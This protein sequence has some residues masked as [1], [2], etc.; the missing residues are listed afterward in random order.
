MQRLRVIRSLLSLLLLVGPGL[1]APAL[2]AEPTIHVQ[3]SAHGLLIEPLVPAAGWQLTVSG[4]SG[5]VTRTFA[6][7][8]TISFR[9]DGL[10]D[11]ADGTWT[12]ELVRVPALDA[13]TRALLDDA[14]GTPEERAV[15]E[16][17]EAAGR[18]PRGALTRSGAFQVSDG[19]VI[20]AETPDPQRAPAT[21]G[22]ATKPELIDDDLL[23][24]EFL[25][26]GDGCQ[27][28]TTTPANDILHLRDA[29]M[30][31]FFEDTTSFQGLPM[32]D[33]RIDINNTAGPGVTAPN[34][35]RFAIEDSDDGTT[36]FTISDDVPDHS[37]FLASSGQVGLGTSTPAA[38]LHV[39]DGSTPTLRLEQD[40]TELFDLYAWDI[41]ADDSAL[42]IRDA[43]LL[44]EPLTVEAG[45]PSHALVVKANG[46][47][48]LGT[49]APGDDFHLL[50]TQNA[51]TFATIQNEDTG[52][53]AAAVLKVDA[54]G[55]GTNL[56]AHGSGR[57]VSR[58]GETLGGWNELLSFTGN[59]LILGTSNY[60]SR[61]V[62]GTEGL[63][64]LE[65]T[66][67]QQVLFNGTLVHAD[68]VFEPDYELPSISEQTEYM[69][70]ERHLPAIGP[71]RVAEDG[72]EVMELGSDRRAIVEELEKA[73]IYIGQL[74]DRLRRIEMELEAEDPSCGLE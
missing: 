43:A 12:W 73:H 39:R 1:G 8:E 45:A 6:T 58:F 32:G 16:S 55:S 20:T 31:V 28:P 40:T 19:V 18:L 2:A 13:E 7:E 47:I 56:I 61:L 36:P 38:D 42:V 64:V 15:R 5:A 21:S 11:P 59:G 23:V 67:D 30:R 72:R 9:L 49:N 37:L 48:G 34:V 66:S 50:R 54:N 63:S 17:L 33:W 41:A 46:H 60:D 22:V 24:S 74:H 25:C 4:P 71:R 65:I 52:T 70:S 53:S 62:L 44:T 51:N 14:R 29:T 10:D 69:W 3:T 27:F 35:S 57:T 26:I 68:Y